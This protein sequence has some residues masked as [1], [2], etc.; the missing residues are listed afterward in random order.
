MHRFQIAERI[1]NGSY[2]EVFKAVE[3]ATGKPCALKIMKHPWDAVQRHQQLE[4][5][6]LKMFA[7]TPSVIHLQESFLHE[8]MLVLVFELLEVNLID[9][10]KAAKTEHDETLSEPE[11]RSIIFQIGL[12]LQSMHR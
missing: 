1:G 8:G 5:S 7:D 2:S 4:V 6:T 3:I 10:Y 12:A 11:I 9:Y